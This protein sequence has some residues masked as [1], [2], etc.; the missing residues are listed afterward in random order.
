MSLNVAENGPLIH[1]LVIPKHL[2]LWKLGRIAGFEK[3]ACCKRS[4]TNKIGK[5]NLKLCAFAA[6]TSFTKF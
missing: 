3:Q 1:Y 4:E 5:C 6:H 2:M